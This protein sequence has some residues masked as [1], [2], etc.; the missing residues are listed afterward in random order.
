M[1]IIVRLVLWP[2]FIAAL[3]VGRLELLARLPGAATPGLLVALTALLLA[4]CFGLRAVRVWTDALDVRLLVLVHVA[5]FFGAYLL[6]LHQRGALPSAFAVPSGWT[7]IIV[8]SLA[9]GVVLLPLRAE[10]RRRAVLLWNTVGLV[11]LLFLV[12]AATRI[13]RSQPWQLAPVQHLPRSRLPTFLVPLLIATH[14]L[15]Y[16]RLLRKL[17]ETVNPP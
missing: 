3:V 5:R 8:A 10:L 15:I 11:D 2:W 9:L 12:A 6:I 16:A 14:A 7:D 1:R 13:G 4:A 17:P